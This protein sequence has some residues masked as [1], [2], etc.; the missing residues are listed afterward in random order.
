[1][2][3]AGIVTQDHWNY[4]GLILCAV[5]VF[6]LLRWVIGRTVRF[7]RRM[8]PGTV[9]RSWLMSLGGIRR[10]DRRWHDYHV[11]SGDQGPDIAAFAAGAERRRRRRF[12]RGGGRR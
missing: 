1:M 6:L 5:A 3:W 7:R 11:P 8:E 2:G 10:P 12:R 9:E 4:F